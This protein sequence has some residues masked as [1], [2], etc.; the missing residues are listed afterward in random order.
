[1]G[2]QTDAAAQLPQVHCFTAE[3]P[4]RRARFHHRIELAA[5]QLD[6]GALAGA[7]GAH[8]HGMLA[9]L[10]LHAEVLEHLA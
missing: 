8:H 6:Q 10:E 3:Q 9:A 5:D 1:L 4:Q 7:V 2:H